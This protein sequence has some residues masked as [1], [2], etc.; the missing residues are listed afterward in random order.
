MELASRGAIGKACDRLK[1]SGVSDLSDPETVRLLR[2]KFPSPYDYNIQAAPRPSDLLIYA[3]AHKVE[4]LQ[5]PNGKSSG[6]WPII[7]KVING[8]PKDTGAGPRASPSTTSSSSSS[9]RR[10]PT[11]SCP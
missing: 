1:S 6:D 8:K 5:L 10:G 2:E 7:A 9:S 3:A 11:A 4:L